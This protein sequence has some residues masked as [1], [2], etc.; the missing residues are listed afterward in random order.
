VV[1]C[2]Y[3]AQATY[4]TQTVV[5]APQEE[6]AAA[7]APGGTSGVHEQLLAGPGA[8]RGRGVRLTSRDG[9][10]EQ[11]I[12]AERAIWPTG[13]SASSTYGGSWSPS[14]LVGPPKVFPRYGDIGGAWAPSSS[15]SRVEWIELQYS[16]DLPVTGVRVYETHKAGN[17]YA[18]VDHSGADELLFAGDVDPRGDASVLEVT[19]DAPR[20]IRRLRVYLSNSSGGFTEIDTVALLARDPLPLQA[21]QHVPPPTSAPSFGGLMA[22]IL[23]LTMLVVAGVLVIVSSGDTESSELLSAPTTTL[24][25]TTILMGTEPLQAIYLRNPRWAQAVVDFSTQYGTNASAATQA[26]SAPDVYP[27]AGDIPQAWAPQSA[28][29]GIEHITLFFGQ[30]QL[31]RAVFWLETYNPGAV[32]RVDDLSDPANPVTLFAGVDP[33][34]GAGRPA[35]AV[36]VQLPAPRPIH[37]VRLYLDTSVVAGWNEIDAVALIP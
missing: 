28:D 26:L 4:L 19:F 37:T 29:R 3:C 14:A 15:S 18:I 11:L 20:V 33:T 9:T 31:T 16:N 17:V 27:A 5:H 2:D 35:M 12:P 34:R 1:T 8:T 36:E 22:G 7:A 25:G 21:R 13:A 6:L 23:A 24:P 30:P 32:V 10:R